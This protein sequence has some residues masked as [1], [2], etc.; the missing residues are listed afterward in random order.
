MQCSMWQSSIR[1]GVFVSVAAALI[2]G[3]LGGRVSELAL[4]FGVFVVASVLGWANVARFAPAA[5]RL[6]VSP[7]R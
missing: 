6:P 4:L 3:L 1:L 5:R 2:V 7:Q